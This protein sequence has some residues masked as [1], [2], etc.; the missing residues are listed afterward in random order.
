LT[1][2]HARR[3][4]RSSDAPPL[5]QVRSLYYF[6]PV[7]EELLQRPLPAHYIDYI[8]DKLRRLTAVCGEAVAER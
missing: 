6:L 5:P 2:T 3:T 8:R 7:I 4:L 1:L